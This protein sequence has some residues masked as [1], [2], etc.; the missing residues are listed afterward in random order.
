[1]KKALFLFAIA[2]S[3]LFFA[4]CSKEL[5]TLSGTTWEKKDG[6]I[7]TTLS[8]TKIQCEIK[9]ASI[10]DLSDYSYAYYSYEYN[11]STVMMYPE[12][13]GKATLKG[14]INDDSM[15]V[16]NMSNQKTIGIF[17]KR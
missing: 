9:I 1:M 6:D 2:L 12:D 5:K 15:S 14:I 7:V 11:S 13:D 4:G 8:F 16:I 10:S 3:T 17:T